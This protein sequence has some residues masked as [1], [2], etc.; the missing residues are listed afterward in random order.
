MN[1]Y[2]SL[3]IG[4]S[5]SIFAFAQKPTLNNDVYDGWR[6]INSTTISKSGIW[7]A[8]Q[9]DPQEGDGEIQLFR[10]NKKITEFARGHKFA[11]SPNEEYA[12]FLVQ[13]ENEVVRQAKRD[14]KKKDDLPKDHFVIYHLNSGKLDTVKNVLGYDMPALF[15]NWYSLKLAKEKKSFRHYK[16]HYVAGYRLCLAR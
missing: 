11:F 10:E 4:I 14:G 16:K 15:G 13:P 5:F 12:L 8:I 1:K 6:Q 3:L 9:I 2:L 7:S